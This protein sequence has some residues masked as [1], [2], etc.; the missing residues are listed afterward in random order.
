M[1]HLKCFPL[2]FWFTLATLACLGMSFGGELQIKDNSIF[3]VVTH[4]S[5]ILKG[6][7]HNHFVFAAEY[8]ASLCAD[9]QD[10]QTFNLEITLPSE[11]L[12]VDDAEV[13]ARW[14]P[15][16]K[17]L[18]I[19]D[20][21]FSELSEGTRAKI[22]KSMLGKSQLDAKNHESISARVLKMEAK[23]EGKFNYGLTLSLTILDTTVEKL[24]SAK[25]E[26]AEGILKLEA[27]GVLS[28]SDFGIKPYSAMFGT[29]SIQDRFHVYIF[30]EA[31]E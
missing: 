17:E 3:A 5:G 12:V 19:L 26:V 23:A 11:G 10:P 7:A 22:R 1:P 21:P 30:I 18:G 24:F 2:L 9:L 28:F 15:R 16:L 14:F 6:A 8:E 31:G 25:V 27:V 29:V 13:S 20:E 4:K